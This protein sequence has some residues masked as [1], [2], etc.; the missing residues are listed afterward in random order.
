LLWELTARIPAAWQPAQPLDDFGGENLRFDDSLGSGSDL[1]EELAVMSRKRR[2]RK[3]NP[4]TS[5]CLGW[6]LAGTV[7]YLLYRKS[8]GLGADPAPPAKEPDDEWWRTPPP[9]PDLDYAPGGRVYGR[10]YW[11]PPKGLPQTPTVVSTQIPAEGGAMVY[12]DQ[13]PTAVAYQLPALSTEDVT[14][15][16]VETAGAV[17]GGQAPLQGTRRVPSFSSGDAT[18]PAVAA[19]TV[20]RTERAKA[21]SLSLRFPR[22]DVTGPSGELTDKGKTLL[23]LEGDRVVQ[24]KYAE[25]AG[26][27]NAK[28]DVPGPD[29]KSLQKMLV[30]DLLNHNLKHSQQEMKILKDAGKENSAEY[31]RFESGVRRDL[32]K[33]DEL[34]KIKRSLNSIE[35]KAV[36][37]IDNAKYREWEA[38]T[39]H[40][41]GREGRSKDVF[42]ASAKA[43]FAANIMNMHEWNKKRAADEAKAKALKEWVKGGGSP[44]DQSFAD[45]MKQFVPPDTSKVR[46]MLDAAAQERRQIVA[47]MEAS[48]EPPPSQKPPSRMPAWAGMF[49]DNM[50]TYRRP[51]KKPST[52]PTTSSPSSGS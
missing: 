50:F 15:R 38:Q 52:P 41:A 19:R 48:I 29:G 6:V 33:L 46:A 5:S 18:S 2:Q 20:E 25:K 28:V 3:Q 23:A 14:R 10:D 16:L 9:Y 47:Q 42:D 12:V 21:A 8:R 1:D 32:A 34:G 22:V 27:L 37:H 4:A 17:Y 35:G 24:N 36:K 26:R 13:P 49:S 40:E 39:K 7:I 31:K 11:H 51:A 30:S 44:G 43:A 45:M